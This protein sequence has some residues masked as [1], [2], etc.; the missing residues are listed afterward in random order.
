M[1]K[2]HSGKF[3][4][5]LAVKNGLTVLNGKGDHVKV[6]APAGRG[7]MIVP[8]HRE[9]AKGT[10]CSIRRWFKLVGI[11]LTVMAPLACMIAGLLAQ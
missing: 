10:E 5:D 9:L 3:Y 4:V 6:V 1:S 7:Y 8:T 11:L 2:T